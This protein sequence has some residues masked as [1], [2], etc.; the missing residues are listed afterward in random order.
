MHVIQVVNVQLADCT[1]PG[2]EAVCGGVGV[3]AA[4]TDPF[5]GAGFSCV[6][7]LSDGASYR[8]RYCSDLDECSS[9][10]CQNGSCSEL[11]ECGFRCDCTPGYAGDRCEVSYPW[12]NV[13]QHET[14][15]LEIYNLVC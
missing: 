14:F 12:L 13:S 8:D 6:C 1:A 15:V 4:P 10:P 7:P 3:C 9:S 11:D 2:S 5:S